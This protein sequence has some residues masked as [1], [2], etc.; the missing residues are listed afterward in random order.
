MS[1]DYNQVPLRHKLPCRI[2]PGVI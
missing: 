1:S 2:T